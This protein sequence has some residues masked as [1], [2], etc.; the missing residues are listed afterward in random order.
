MLALLAPLLSGGATGILGT[1]IQRFFDTKAKKIELEMLNQKHQNDIALRRLDIELAQA[2]YKATE[3]KADAEALAASYKT[4]AGWFAGKNYS[5]KQ[6]WL[7]IVV[8]VIRK[9]VRPGLTLYL[10]AITTIVYFK[11]ERLLNGDIMLPGMAYDL[12][13]Q[14]IQTVLYLTA[15]CITWWFG[16]RYKGVSK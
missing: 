10:C 13:G 14:I 16:S 8:D 9:L 1:V 15:T 3:A 2:G 5:P 12:V 7:L 11:A 6:Q 4:E